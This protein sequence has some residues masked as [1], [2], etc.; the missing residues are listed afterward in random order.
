MRCDPVNDRMLTHFYLSWNLSPVGLTARCALGAGCP[1][2]SGLAAL[3]DM[4]YSPPPC[5]GERGGIAPHEEG[6][7]GRPSLSGVVINAA[8]FRRLF[9]LCP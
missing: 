7:F 4:R 5:M 9:L 3:G 8:R 1:Q 2:R 6:A